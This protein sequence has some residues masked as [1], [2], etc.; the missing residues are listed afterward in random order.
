[1][2]D[3]DSNAA[4]ALD[5]EAQ[6]AIGFR[7]EWMYHT[8]RAIHDM[9]GMLIAGDGDGQN[10]D[11]LLWAMQELAQSQCRDLEALADR[12]QGTKLGYYAE[13]FTEPALI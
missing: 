13:H 4:P 5:K 9:T 8:S 10:N 3:S 1:M 6:Q 12:L 2:A 7:L 11:S